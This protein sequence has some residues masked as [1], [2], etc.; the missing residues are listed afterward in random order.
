MRKQQKTGKIPVMMTKKRICLGIAAH[1]DAGK[2]T[3]CEAMLYTAGKLKTPGRVDHRNS[4]MDTE[5]FERARGITAFTKQAVFHWRDT[6]FTLIDTPGHQDLFAETMRGLRVPDAAILV[7][8]GSEGCQADTL[9]LWKQ[10]EKK[11]IPVWVFVSK[12][13]LPGPEKEEILHEL[14]GKL[15][16]RI[17]ELS[18]IEEL[19]TLDERCM[20]EYLENGWISSAAIISAIAGQR[21][22]PCFFGSGLK[23]QGIADFLDSL[24]QFTPMLPVADRFSALCFKIS[25]D[26]KGQRLTQ[27]RLLGGTLSVREILRYYDRSGGFQ[28]EKITGIRIYSGG[29]YE[30]CEHVEA[31]QVCSLIG[32]SRT[33]AGMLLGEEA[34]IQVHQEGGIRR[35][36]LRFENSDDEI[37]NL[38][39]LQLLQEEFPELLPEAGKQGLSVC[40][41]GRMQ[42]ELLISLLMERFG[43]EVQVLSGYVIYRE[44]IKKRVE[45]IGHFEPLRHY[46][47]V[48]LLLEPL[49]AG[50]GLQIESICLEDELDRNWQNLILEALQ[51]QPLAGVLT[52]SALTDMR[53]CLA[54]G[55]AHPKHTEGGDFRE[56]TRRALRHGLMEAES[57]LLE[58]VY[59]FTME[60]PNEY[61]GRAIS[62]LRSMC[63]FY[64]AP[65]TGE[66]TARITGKVP[67]S[68]A[69]DY[70]ET[71]L[72]YTHGRGKLS[73]RAGGEMPCHNTDTVL[74]EV[75]YDPERDVDWPADSIFCSH[76]A[77]HAV[78]WKKV[79][80]Y[81]H[82]PSV[83]EREKTEPDAIAH[84]LTPIDD[85]ELEAIMLREFGPVKRP[86]YTR[87]HTEEAQQTKE[88]S[89][90]GRRMLI[91]DGYNFIFADPALKILSR[92]SLDAARS[93]LMD[94]LSNYCGYTGQELLLVFDGFRT[95]GNTGSH[96]EYTNIHVGFTPEGE[97]ADAYI[98]KIV[99]EIGK[100][101]TVAVVTADNM[102]RVSAMRSG[103]LRIS[104]QE[105]EEELEEG[106]RGIAELLAHSN[107]LAH[108]TKI[109]EAKAQKG[110]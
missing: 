46:A 30:E 59:E 16:E 25:R 58:P 40:L 98:E 36:G 74:S 71:L 60:L 95:A 48:H 18:D 90:P 4:S 102:I 17:A 87:R 38:H 78:S 93:R 107:F 108:Q 68:E 101:E 29:R 50:S 12:M 43:L 55:R 61:L 79:R 19:A 83:L 11:Q 3:L 103:V 94:R 33:Y 1:V 73:L 70:R 15:S 42:A 81:M 66:S 104:P 109:T 64:D 100:N 45:G 80:E 27:I 89:V 24:D 57:L 69:D 35:Y 23:Q 84:R 92:E 34:G 31:G 41:S 88:Y 52:G 99:S 10:L 96:G 13:D 54:S 75:A 5:D 21:I 37:H 32:L 62:D 86:E 85:R 91:V 53:I 7:I 105:F 2:T 63:A 44:T 56:A 97:S 110:T 82:L 28:E 20:D 6:E 67:V 9:T 47:E 106:E 51:A 14:K 77:G 26:V 39:A 65:Q 8:S 22:C 49:P 72:S 76:G